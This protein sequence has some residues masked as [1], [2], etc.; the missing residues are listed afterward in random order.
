MPQGYVRSAGF[1]RRAAVAGRIENPVKKTL[2]DIGPDGVILDASRVKLGTVMPD[3]SVRDATNAVIGG[4]T[5]EN[6]FLDNT[7]R[8]IARLLPDWRLVGPTE[9]PLAVVR[10]GAILSTELSPIALYSPNID[11]KWVLA[12]FVFFSGLLDR[13]AEALEAIR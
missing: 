7:N 1:G 4:I 12:W 2:A 9:L 6:V 8:V 3:F 13:S 5:A 11:A 10:A